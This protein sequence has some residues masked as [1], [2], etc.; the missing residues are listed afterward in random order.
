MT[1]IALATY[2]ERPQFTEEETLLR[3]PLETFN[4][5]VEVAVWND[6]MVDWTAYDAVVIRSTWDYHT[7]VALFLDWVD[8]V[9]QLGVAVWNRPRV[10]QWNSDKIY[11][12][13]LHD[14]RIPLI[15]T[16][17]ADAKMNLHALMKQQGWQDVVVKPRYGATSMGIQRVSLAEAPHFSGSLAHTFIQPVMPQIHRGE[18]SLI[19]LNGLY[20]HTILKVAQADSI[21]VNYEYGGTVERIH[22]PLVF[23][24]YAHAV[25]Q[26]AAQCLHMNA[27]DFLYARVDGLDVE[28]TF[29]L[30]E[31]ELIEPELYIR[32][33]PHRAPEA[34]AQAIYEKV[35]RA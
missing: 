29:V 34:F 24:E 30:M 7:Q 5:D 8:Y 19:F 10:L 3:P 26:V 15:P 11:L 21:F 12:K 27:R 28:E 35:N 4:I 2:H 18:Y 20:S 17:W 14:A 22:P 9:E 1:K 6:P 23:I 13:A 31:L 25:L 32:Y 33:D 16:V